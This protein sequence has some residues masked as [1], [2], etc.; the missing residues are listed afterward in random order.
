MNSQE[1]AAV[2]CYH[3]RTIL[4]YTI[5]YY[6]TLYYTILYYAMLYYTILYYTV[7]LF[8]NGS[9]DAADPKTSTC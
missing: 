5:L 2:Y 8:F 7:P 3:S 1:L 9:A 6:T 4:Y